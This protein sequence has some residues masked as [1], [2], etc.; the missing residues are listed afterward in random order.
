MTAVSCVSGL[1]KVYRPSPLNTV[2]QKSTTESVC[3]LRIPACSNN[4]IPGTHK[5]HSFVPLSQN[6]LI[7][8][9]FSYSTDSKEER[10]SLLDTELRLE[11]YLWVCHL[12]LPWTLVACLC[13]A[14]CADNS[15][16][17]LTILYPHGPSRSF[18]YPSEQDVCLLKI[19]DILTAADPRRTGRTYTLRQK[20]CRAASQKLT[21]LANDMTVIILCTSNK[22][23]FMKNVKECRDVNRQKS[24]RTRSGCYRHTSHT[25]WTHSVVR[26]V[27]AL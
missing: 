6:T 9:I 13:T 26:I 19:A 11:H 2:A 3:I 7:A 16:A 24:I 21:V 14:T 22:K 1:Q 15:E 12:P 23:H 10:V 4:N 25:L 20:E 27:R 5:L 18:R 17:K 8:K